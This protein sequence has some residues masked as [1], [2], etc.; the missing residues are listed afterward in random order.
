MKMFLVAAAILAVIIPPTHASTLVLDKGSAALIAQ[1]DVFRTAAPTKLFDETKA[2]IT[3]AVADSPASDSSPDQTL[4]GPLED[5]EH[6]LCLAIAI[7]A[8]VLKGHLKLLRF[9]DMGL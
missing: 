7:I 2:D 4:D 9:A 6:L 5:Q 3:G 1:T 8:F